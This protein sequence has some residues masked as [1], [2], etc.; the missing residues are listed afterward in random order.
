MKKVTI[1]YIAQGSYWSARHSFESIGFCIKEK[2]TEFIIKDAPKEYIKVVG[3][4]EVE[5]LVAD[6]TNDKRTTEYFSSLATEVFV[7][8]KETGENQTLAQIYN[9]LFRKATGDYICIVPTGVFLQ[10]DW[11]IEIIYHYS[12]IGKSGVVGVVSKID[13]TIVLPLPTTDIEH[14]INAFVPKSNL[15][16][17]L[18]F[19]DKQHLY[20]IGAFDES[21]NLQGNEVN[22]FALRCIALGYYNY[23]VPSTTCIFIDENKSVSPNEYAISNDNLHITLLEMK[24][25]KNYYLP[26]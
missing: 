1:C 16:K 5:L 9:S 23:Y 19:F 3:D 25:S 7:Y 8:S 4:L 18:S 26:L 14:F 13:E 22:Q 15:I 24:K 10:K 21:V 2:E 17:G 11:L 12:N 20:L 6:L